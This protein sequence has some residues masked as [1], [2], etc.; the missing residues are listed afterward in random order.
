MAFPLM[1]Y[2]KESEMSLRFSHRLRVRPQIVLIALAIALVAV[3]SGCAFRIIPP[4]TMTVYRAPDGK[5]EQIHY[6]MQV[7]VHDRE[8]FWDG[9]QIKDNIFG[10]SDLEV[11]RVLDMLA[12]LPNPGPERRP[13][14]NA[15]EWIK[16]QYAQLPPWP[17][18]NIA[19]GLFEALG[20]E[21]TSI[22]TAYGR[23]GLSIPQLIYLLHW[24]RASMGELNRTAGYAIPGQDGW[25]PK[26]WLA[27][28]N[29][30]MDR[31]EDALIGSYIWIF[32]GLDWCM[33]VAISGGE[34]GWQQTVWTVAVPFVGENSRE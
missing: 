2:G 10:L 27:A 11:V 28:P 19:G 33:D 29:R 9:H 25:I 5:P 23:R 34:W 18:V 1:G 30:A 17:P 22:L 13:I 16:N 24:V 20:L 31:T 12:D 14:E 4:E 3:L 21:K 6:P 26:K 8:S 32:Q 15:I 7:V